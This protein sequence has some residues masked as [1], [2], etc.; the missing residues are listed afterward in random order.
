MMRHILGLVG[1]VT[2]LLGST[3][4]LAWSEETHQT[5]GEIA[6]DELAAEHSERLAELMALVRAHPHYAQLLA[7]SNGLTGTARDRAIF[8]WLARWP[9]D[10]RGTAA[11]R[12]KWHY[13]LRVVHGRSWLWP[14]RNGTAQYAFDGNAALLANR[15]A[16]PAHRAVAI[17]W[18]LHIIGDIQ[19]PLHAGHQMTSDFPGTDEAGGLAWVRRSAGGE[20]TN[21]H[22]YWDKFLE[23][24]VPASVTA[25]T[26]WRARLTTQFP[27]ASLRELRPITSPNRAFATWLDESLLIAHRV[28]YRGSFLAASPAPTRAPVVSAADNARARAVTERRVTLGGYRAADVLAH[29]LGS[30]R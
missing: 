2:A 5:I 9:D 8:G 17:G 28:A 18:L 15:A 26:T 25:G 22:Q 30:A 24:S 14:F 12:P 16:S 19:Q 4:A 10:I 29:A 23:R 3:P 7:H 13:E 27:R 6:Y 11:D 20:L 21:L 1:A